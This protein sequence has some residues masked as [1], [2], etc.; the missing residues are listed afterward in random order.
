MYSFHIYMTAHQLH[1]FDVKFASTL[2]IE[3]TLLHDA[4]RSKRC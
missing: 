3:R 1:P 2:F 4:A